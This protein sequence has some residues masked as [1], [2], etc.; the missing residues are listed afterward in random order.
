MVTAVLDKF[1]ED[2]ELPAKSKK[3]LKTEDWRK[4]ILSSETLLGV[5]IT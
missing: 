2:N 4:L 5:R 3:G 1:I